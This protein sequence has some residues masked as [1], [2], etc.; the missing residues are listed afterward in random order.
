MGEEAQ[1][2]ETSEPLGL[3]QGHIQEVEHLFDEAT[4]KAII[5]ETNPRSAAGPQGLRYSHLQATLCDELVEEITEFVALVFSGRILKTF[6]PCIRA[7]ICLRGGKR[8][9]QSRAATSSGGLL[10]PF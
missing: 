9:G 3:V 4:I 7:P 8:R 10:T 2:D 5:K 6:G 1:P